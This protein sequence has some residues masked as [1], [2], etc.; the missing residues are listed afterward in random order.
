MERLKVKRMQITLECPILDKEVTADA[1][2]EQTWIDKDG[3]YYDYF[4]EVVYEVM[5]PCGS[6]HECIR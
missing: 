1:D 6:T 5:C 3:E 2:I 4:G